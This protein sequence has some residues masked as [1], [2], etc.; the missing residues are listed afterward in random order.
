MSI[1]HAEKFLSQV[2]HLSAAASRPHQGTQQGC[3]HEL[4]LMHVQQRLVC[5]WTRLCKGTKSHRHPLISLF[6]QGQKV[7]KKTKWKINEHATEQ[8]KSYKTTATVPRLTSYWHKMFIY[9]RDQSINRPRQ[10]NIKNSNKWLTA[11]LNK[12]WITVLLQWDN[13]L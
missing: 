1:Q 8:R 9:F 6:V 2:C 12:V 3:C 10:I 13:F 5:Q 7:Q 4:S 11:V